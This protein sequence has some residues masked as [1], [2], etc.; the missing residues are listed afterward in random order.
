MDQKSIIIT[1]GAGAGKGGLGRCLASSLAEKG[2]A[3]ILWD[4]QDEHAKGVF[5]QIR[6]KDGW[7]SYVHCDCTDEEQ[8]ANAVRYTLSKTGRIDAL[9]NNASWSIEASHPI[10]QIDVK[11]WDRQIAVNLKSHFLA[12]KHAIPYMLE[13][14]TS[15][16]VNIGATAARRGGDGYA[17]FAAAKAGLESLTRSIAADYGKDGLRCNCV[18]PGLFLDIQVDRVLSAI[19]KTREG[20]EKIDRQSLLEMGHGSGQHVIE[21]VEFLLSNASSWI[22]GESLVVD[23]GALSHCPAWADSNEK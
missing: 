2:W 18:V 4:V 16:I 14:P 15:A 5:E 23:G 8:V 19:S 9:V 13:Q 10:H 11:D 17:A 22:T 20:I 1:G 6:M 3:V 21:A 12:S 7:V